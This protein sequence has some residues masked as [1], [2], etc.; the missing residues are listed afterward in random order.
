MN[1]FKSS[2]GIHSVVICRYVESS[3]LCRLVISGA[4]IASSR[5]GLMPSHYSDVCKAVRRGVILISCLSLV[6]ALSIRLI[7]C[8]VE[9]N[10]NRS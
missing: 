9:G 2:S 6:V 8:L 10:Q 1:G 3:F 7:I 5:D 4:V